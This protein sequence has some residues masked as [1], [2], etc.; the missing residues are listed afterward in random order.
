MTGF[1]LNL[2]LIRVLFGTD[3]IYLGIRTGARRSTL[4]YQTL[5]QDD[6]INAT[7]VIFDFRKETNKI[8]VLRGEI[9]GISYSKEDM[10]YLSKLIMI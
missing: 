5:K 4:E 3:W 6:P 2:C 9:D 1:L 10:L 8:E 7:K